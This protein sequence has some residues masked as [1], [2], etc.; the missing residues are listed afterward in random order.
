MAA[1]LF[2]LSLK[3]VRANA[4]MTLAEWAKE[5]NVSVSTVSAWENGQGEPSLSQAQKMS[6]LAQIPL[7]YIFVHLESH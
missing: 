1:P 2:K 7:D 3:A 5:L 4:D 6:K